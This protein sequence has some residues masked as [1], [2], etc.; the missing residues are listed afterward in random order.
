MLT[1]EPFLDVKH[2]KVDEFF[3]VEMS[4]LFLVISAVEIE[5][6]IWFMH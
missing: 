2:S 6:A 4:M 1:F 5:W 3:P